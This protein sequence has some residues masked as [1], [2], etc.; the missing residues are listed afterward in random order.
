MSTNLH[1]TTL[2]ALFPEPSFY[3]PVKAVHLFAL[4]KIDKSLD[5]DD[6]TM[7]TDEMDY[8]YAHACFTVD[9]KE[10]TKYM[11]MGKDYLKDKLDDIVANIEF[12]DSIKIIGEVQNAILK[13]YKATLPFDSGDGV[14]KNTETSDS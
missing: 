12:A 1:P 6:G 3:K 7:S 14:K 2:E 11:E 5:K 4:K 13:A 8:M 9:C 10:L